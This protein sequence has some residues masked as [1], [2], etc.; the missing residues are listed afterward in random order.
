MTPTRR[1]LLAAAAGLGDGSTTFR[2]ALAAE[3]Q[4]ADAPGTVTPEMVANAEW[5]AGV[6]LTED[7]RKTIAG[8]MTQALAGFAALHKVEVPNSVPPAIHF[9]PDLDGLALIGG[10]GEVTPPKVDA[11][12]PEAADDLAFLPLTHLAAAAGS[13]RRSSTCGPS[14]RG[15][16]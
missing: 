12:K 16:C 15:R 3:A 13:C 5:V 2:R 6:T 7:Q 4:K 9:F 10:R 14:G 8:G 1:Q 11:A